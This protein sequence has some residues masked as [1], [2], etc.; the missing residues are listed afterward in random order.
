MN[1]AIATTL[2]SVLGAG[3]FGGLYGMFF[4]FM[5][6]TNAKLDKISDDVAGLD[7]K[8][9]GAIKDL[10]IKLSQKFTV[11]INALDIRVSD[12][13]KGHGERLAR[14]E[15]KLDIDPPAEAA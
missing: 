3:L 14:I 2:I 7:T 6:S 11:E 5:R 1:T 4:H 13:L 12:Q 9:T 8:F 15:T 10:E